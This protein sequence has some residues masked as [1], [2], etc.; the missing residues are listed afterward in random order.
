[1]FR[2]ISWIVRLP[3][4][5]LGLPAHSPKKITPRDLSHRAHVDLRLISI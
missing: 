3:P 4:N 1:M 5:L 2:A